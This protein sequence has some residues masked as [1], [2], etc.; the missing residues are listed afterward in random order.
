MP[1]DSVQLEVELITPGR[2][3]QGFA[4]RNSRGRPYGGFAGTVSEI[5]S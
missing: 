4:L 3:G 1:G 2:H 5:V